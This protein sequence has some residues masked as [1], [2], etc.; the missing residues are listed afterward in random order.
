MDYTLAARWAAVAA[1]LMAVIVAL[2]KEQLQ[3]LLFK[4]KFKIT[5]GTRPPF[6][7]KTKSFVYGTGLDGKKQLLWHGSIYWARLWVQNAGNRRGESVEVFVTKVERLNRDGT[8]V[9]VDGFIP[10]NLRWANTDPVKPEIFC[11]MNP[12]MGRFCDFGS[13]ADPACSTLQEVRGAPRGVATFDL[14]LQTALPDDAHRLSPG[15]Y[16]LTLKISA[17]NAK[18]VEKVAKVS[19]SGKWTEDAEGMFGN[20]LGVSLL[21]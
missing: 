5:V 16:R 21:Q 9:A 15:D 20:E 1:T 17:A 6:S 7:V 12:E 2:F 19:I 4:P 10:S 14:V 8:R 11:T 18:P 13:I 3:S